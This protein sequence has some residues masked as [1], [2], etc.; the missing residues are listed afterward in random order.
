MVL[1]C[2]KTGF[3]NN[4]RNLYTSKPHIYENIDSS[5]NNHILFIKSN[6]ESYEFIFNNETRSEILRKIGR[7]AS[8]PDL[9][10]TWKDAGKISRI[11]RKQS[12]KLED[13]SNRIKI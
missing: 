8:N 13:I 1:G 12:E 11:I 6:R 5:G 7:Y 4:Y 3:G 2:F 10:L 9:S